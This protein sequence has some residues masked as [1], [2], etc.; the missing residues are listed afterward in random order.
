MADELDVAMEKFFDNVKQK[1][2]LTLTDRQK[3]T[4]AAGEVFLTHLRSE[5]NAKHRSNHNDKVYG[6][7]ADNIDMMPIAK[8]NGDEFLDLGAQVVGFPFFYHAMNAMRLND[9]T[10]KIPADH[11]ITNLR[12]DN[13]V[14]QEM[15]AAEAPIW[16]A[17]LNDN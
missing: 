12:N 10:K 13:T 11:W 9:G 7:M 5:A 2:D 3:M 15:L 17:K 8:G 16:R 4:A 1:V 6:H 14:I